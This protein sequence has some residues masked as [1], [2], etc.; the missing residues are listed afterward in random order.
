VKAVHLL[1]VSNIFMTF[2]CMVAAVY[3]VFR[4]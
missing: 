2:M 3:F 4:F 1:A